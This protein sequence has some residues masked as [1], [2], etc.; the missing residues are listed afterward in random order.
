M[1]LAYEVGKAGGTLPAVMNAANE[2]LVYKFLKKRIKYKD[3]YR[4]V[5][6]TVANHENIVDPSLAEILAVAAET[7]EKLAGI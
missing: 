3:I 1:G 5:A 7:K 6:E 4:Y 2:V